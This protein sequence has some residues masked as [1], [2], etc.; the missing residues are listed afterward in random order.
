VRVYFGEACATKFDK[1]K[2]IHVA[3]ERWAKA[4]IQM[5][6]KCAEAAGLRE[7]FPDEFGGETT[8]E[9]MTGRDVLE[10]EVVQPQAIKPAE[11]LSEQAKTAPAQE[12]SQAPEP[13]KTET[14]AVLGTVVELEPVSGPKNFGIVVEAIEKG[15]AVFAKLDTGYIAGTRDAEMQKTIGRLVDSKQRVEL[16]CKAPKKEGFAPVIEEINPITETPA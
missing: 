13:V 5:L 6:T 7:A 14:V 11:R 12:S 3:N 16:V 8:A 4:P 9:E 15:N 2:K 10:A 1:D